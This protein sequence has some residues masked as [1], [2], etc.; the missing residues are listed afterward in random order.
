MFTYIKAK[1]FKSFKNIEFN[2][3]R[4][5]NETNNF[6]AIYGENGSG[7]S[8][9]VEIFKFLQQVT[10]ARNIDV[11]TNQLP[12]EFLELKEKVMKNEMVSPE[13]KMISS[14]S[15]VLEKYRMIDEKEDTEIEYGFKID[16]KEGFYYIRFNSE[17][18]EEKLY[19]FLN[20]QKGYYFQIKKE[21]YF[22]K[23][24]LN[25]N[26]FIN[27]KY[28]LE[29]EENIDKYWGKYSLLSLLAFE[30]TDKN[31]EYVRNNIS[32]KMFDVIG[33]FISMT[34]H[35]NNWVFRV[36][37]NNFLEKRI[38][39]DLK[40]GFIEKN[41]INEIKKYENILNIFFT[42]AYADIK[43]VKYIIENYDDKIKYKLYFTKMIGGTLRDIPVELESEGTKRI[44]EKFDTLIGSIMGETVIVDEIDNGI[45]DL[46][47][48]NIILSIK[49]EITGQLII[50]T[51]NTLLLE[52]LPKE[53]IYFLSSDYNGYKEIN[54]IKE[55]KLGIQ[56]NHNIRDLYFKGM[57]GGIPTTSY[58][59]FEDIK[60]VLE[61][62]NKEEEKS[63]E[64]ET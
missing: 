34:I 49:D 63:N 18:V 46:L 47:M 19:Y 4:T 10:I 29:I 9:L 24:E 2:L 25:T 64:E 22:I 37:P 50:T 43:N 51:H 20:R 28:R 45:H 14:L 16:G 61:E 42:Q 35:V 38:L 12:K 21:N 3:N 23:K 6:I 30:P 57:F 13:I 36:I 27:E 53:N 39:I 11:A 41:K 62:T 52:V 59:D 15:I 60:F 7:K 40:S 32:S 54:S 8:N 56:K 1:N 17:I 26:I 31:A 55:Y 58:V 48:K 33:K 44:I 5:K